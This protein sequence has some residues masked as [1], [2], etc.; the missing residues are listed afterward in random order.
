MLKAI[1]L[2][3]EQA[4]GS[5]RLTTGIDNTEEE[6]NLAV[7]AIDEIVDDLRRLFHK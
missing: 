3:E 7:S 5:L 4:K 1:G 2:A 6:I